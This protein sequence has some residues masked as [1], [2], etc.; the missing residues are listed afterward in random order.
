MKN[1]AAFTL[2]FLATILL[3]ATVL[4]T[5]Q[6]CGTTPFP[7]VPP[8]P[9]PA[10]TDGGPILPDSGLDMS[11]PDLPEDSTLS[12][13]RAACANLLALGCPEGKAPACAA[14][15][16]MAQL[17]RIT[18]LHPDKI[19]KAKSIAEVRAIGSVACQ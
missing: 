8:G 11:L 18:D 4:S 12:L 3:G 19:A 10:V 5:C 16:R 6:S 9:P 13:C 14:D 7:P 15:C 1:V 17:G 2:S